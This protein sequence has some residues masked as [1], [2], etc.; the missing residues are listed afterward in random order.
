MR[1]EDFVGYTHYW[2]VD[3]T[4]SNSLVEKQYQKG[5]A[6]CN[7]IIKAYQEANGGLAGFSAH[8]P[9]GKYGGIDVNGSE[10]VGSCE[11]FVMRDTFLQNNDFEFCK[12][13]RYDYDV[14][15]TA[16]LVALKNRLGVAIEVSSD[17]DSEDW[18]QGLELAK[19]V[20]KL[21]RLKIPLKQE[22]A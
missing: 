1:Q 12:T 9:S 21:K 17:G 8:A 11:N 20:L 14:V 3:K 7:K 16:C 10:R 15:V 22:R 18:K 19:T 2:R 5:I 13:R 6:D 4:Q